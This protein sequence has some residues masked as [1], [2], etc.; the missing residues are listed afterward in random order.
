[1]R[2][3]CTKHDHMYAYGQCP[4]CHAENKVDNLRQTP[5][6]GNVADNVRKA[7]EEM[8]EHMHQLRN[9]YE[10]I[11]CWDVLDDAFEK[12]CAERERYKAQSEN[13]SLDLLYAQQE[14]D[15]YFNA[16]LEAR[17]MAQAA[18]RVCDELR[19]RLAKAREALELF[20]KYFDCDGETPEKAKAKELNFHE[21]T[22][23]ARQALKEL[24]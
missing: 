15:K 17:A 1:M 12:V 13:Y 7:L 2:D 23:K 18:N 16:E 11:D 19:E 6:G 10:A 14:R 20:F 3:Y 9:K 5:N 8:R 22:H 4:E 21:F 24:G